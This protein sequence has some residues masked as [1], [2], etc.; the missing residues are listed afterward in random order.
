MDERYEGQEE[1]LSRGVEHP[2]LWG[3]TTEVMPF[4]ERRGSREPSADVNHPSRAEVASVRCPAT[5]GLARG[6]PC[7]NWE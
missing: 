2:T 3:K 7:A 6:G 5:M 1:A 4:E